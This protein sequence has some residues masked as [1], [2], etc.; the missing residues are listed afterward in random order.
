MVICAL[1][2]RPF[3]VRGDFNVM[4]SQPPPE[5]VESYGWRHMVED[6]RHARE[7][8]SVDEL[9]GDSDCADG[10]CPEPEASYLQIGRHGGV[11]ES[12]IVKSDDDC[13]FI[14]K[15]GEWHEISM[16]MNRDAVAKI[17]TVFASIPGDTRV[18]FGMDS[19]DLSPE[20][21]GN[22]VEVDGVE[23][24]AVPNGPY[25]NRHGSDSSGGSD[26]A[27]L[28]CSLP[29]GHGFVLFTVGCVR[30]KRPCLPPER[31][32]TG[33]DLDIVRYCR[34]GC[35]MPAKRGF[36]GD[37]GFVQLGDDDHADEEDGV[38]SHG[39]SHA[40]G[41]HEHGHDHGEDE[42]HGHG[43]AH[44]E[45]SEAMQ[46][47]IDIGNKMQRRRPARIGNG[48][49]DGADNDPDVSTVLI[50]DEFSQ[51]TYLAREATRLL[52][53]ITTFADNTQTPRSDRVRV[54]PIPTKDEYQKFQDRL[55]SNIMPFVTKAWRQESFGLLNIQAE[56]FPQIMGYR[57][58]FSTLAAVGGA[59]WPFPLFNNALADLKWYLTQKPGYTSNNTYWLELINDPKTLI[60]VN[61][62]PV[63]PLG[64]QGV[65]NV[66]TRGVMCNGCVKLDNAWNKMVNIHEVGHNFGL[67]HAAA[68]TIKLSYGN[69]YSW[70]GNY[71]FVKT[72]SYGLGDKTLLQW[73]PKTH[74]LIV[75]PEL[76]EDLNVQNIVL[77]P[78]TNPSALNDPRSTVGIQMVNDV[79]A[80]YDI[81]VAYY[82]KADAAN[83]IKPGVYITWHITQ[84][85]GVSSNVG[86]I[87]MDSASMTVAQ[88]DALLQV[89]QTYMDLDSRVVVYYEKTTA[90][91][92]AVVHIFRPPNEASVKSIRGRKSNDG[93]LSFVDGWFS[94]VPAC[95]NAEALLRS[96][97][98]G[99]CAD[100]SGICSATITIGE[101]SLSGA[102]EACP[103]TCGKCSE[104]L[105][106]TTTRSCEDATGEQISVYASL[107]QCDDSYASNCFTC[108]Q[109]SMNFC[110]R[111]PLQAQCAQ[112]CDSCPPAA[113]SAATAF[114]NP[115]G[116]LDW[117]MATGKQRQ[118]YWGG[119]DIPDNY[120]NAEAP[121]PVPTPPPP[122]PTPGP[123]PAPEEDKKS[124]A[125]F[126]LESVVSSATGEVSIGDLATGDLVWTATGLEPVLF[127]LHGGTEISSMLRV[128]HSDGVLEVSAGHRI[129]I[130]DGN[131][132]EASKLQIG[133]VLAGGAVVSSV[134][135]VK[136]FGFRAPVTFSGTI[137][138]GNVMASSYVGFGSMMPHWLGHVGTL[139]LRVLFA[140]FDFGSGKSA[141]RPVVLICH[142][143]KTIFLMEISPPSNKP[144]RGDGNKNRKPKLGQRR[145][146][147][148]S[149]PPAMDASTE[150][151]TNP[152]ASDSPN[153]Y[154]LRSGFGAE[155]GILVAKSLFLAGFGVVVMKAGICLQPPAGDLSDSVWGTIWYANMLVMAALVVAIVTPIPYIFFCLNLGVPQFPC[156]SDEHSPV[157]ER[158]SH[159]FQNPSLLNDVL[160]DIVM[161]LLALVIVT[162]LTFGESYGLSYVSK[163][164]G[165]DGGFA[166][167]LLFICGTVCI[168]RAV[169][170]KH[171]GSI[172]AISGC[173][174]V[175]TLIF[176]LF[177]SDPT[178]PSNMFL[179]LL[180]SA[181]GLIAAAVERAMTFKRHGA[182][183]KHAR[184]LLLA[185]VGCLAVA[186]ATVCILCIDIWGSGLDSEGFGPAGVV[187]GLCLVGVAGI[188]V[189]LYFVWGFGVTRIFSRAAT[190]RERRISMSAR[191]VV[192][193]TFDRAAL[194]AMDRDMVLDRQNMLNQ[195]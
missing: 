63:E 56:L 66:G 86:S 5:I 183:P 137:V 76:F 194:N 114:Q 190:V 143:D 127:F 169:F 176:L 24:V 122:T 164:D 175:T 50:Q 87:L 96:S 29:D 187:V 47:A 126:S 89:G 149:P 119:A 23:T 37:S 78:F 166:F 22:F 155:A 10:V 77:S 195:N 189:W 150:S 121:T 168:A 110:N 88:E 85:G 41:V 58:D 61:T 172:F 9:L 40:A 108:D 179:L 95:T 53:V 141:A 123:T 73:I 158:S 104:L 111:L 144:L 112:L 28:N 67:R 165:V 26:L 109:E 154:F 167:V 90:D 107:G 54:T 65:G 91:G 97:K 43:H 30:D 146:K 71:N 125:C 83:N 59:Y 192:E 34:A 62:D 51:Q 178:Y 79:W 15:L 38:H 39:H 8:P 173:V 93:K 75:Q 11:I 81:F 55:Q 1:A 138:V 49:L 70:M 98:Q 99:S 80:Y 134:E 72:N 35:T 162:L 19:E 160:P 151:L 45:A 132:V 153:V 21:F 185:E 18:D 124:S 48:T 131:A 156:P 105:S 129:F 33:L 117:D 177:I 106:A 6:A 152:L 12:D 140:M 139:P 16:A 60:I 94:G 180:P 182:L 170:L 147:S 163:Q 148:Q 100:W 44:G 25:Y 188:R 3:L 31:N 193:P 120:P 57:E 142:A 157:E 46:E 181:I 191:E 17:K 186:A 113:D 133:D 128:T 161:A 159:E 7:V 145:K 136:V 4:I 84:Y 69:I 118:P 135:L 52:Y 64:T 92:R 101:I 130:S 184:M 27:G 102:R 13:E 171:G 116:G 115:A 42:H 2:L 36:P 68:F 74:L 14:W 103:E 174:I 20:D 32:Y 82:N